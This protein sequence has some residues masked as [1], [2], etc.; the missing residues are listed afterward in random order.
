M[1]KKTVEAVLISEWVDFKVTKIKGAFY[2][3]IKC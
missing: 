2:D 3:D 1:C